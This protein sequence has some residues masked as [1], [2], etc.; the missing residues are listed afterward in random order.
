MNLNDSQCLGYWW[1]LLRN[2]LESTSTCKSLVGD[3]GRFKHTHDWLKFRFL[4]WVWASFFCCWRSSY[5][6]YSRMLR[7]IEVSPFFLPN[8]SGATFLSWWNK[9]LDPTLRCPS[10][11]LQRVWSCRIMARCWLPKAQFSDYYP[12]FE[13]GWEI[14]KLKNMGSNNGSDM[15][16]H[17]FDNGVTSCC[18]VLN[19]FF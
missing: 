18:N 14:Q 9:N 10:T 6:F 3:L 15:I 8:H 16:T 19:V 5:L 17:F 11:F 2:C 13:S 12:R 4:G 7:F 1:K